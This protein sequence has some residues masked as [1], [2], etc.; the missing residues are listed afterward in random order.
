MSRAMYERAYGEKCD[1]GFRRVTD[2]AKQ[3]RADIKAA[4]A[5]GQLPGS[6]KNYSV[7]SRSYSGGQAIDIAAKGLD[8]MYQW[9]EGIKPGSKRPFENGEGWTAQSC[10]NVWCSAGGQYRDSEHAKPHRIKTVEGERV[11]AILQGFWDAYN[12]NGSEIQVD[13]FDRLYW[14]VPEIVDPERGW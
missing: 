7:R 8:G 4:I 13:Y 2:I 14:G 12:W 6:M 11:L 1:G 5:S 3:I 10:G 9:C